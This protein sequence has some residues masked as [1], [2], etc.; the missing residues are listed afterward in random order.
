MSQKLSPVWQHCSNKKLQA[1]AIVLGFHS[2]EKILVFK[3]LKYL[4]APEKEIAK[5]ES[6]TNT[7]WG[8]E[9]MRSNL[10]LKHTPRMQIRHAD[11]LKRNFKDKNKT[12]DDSACFAIND[13]YFAQTDLVNQAEIRMWWILN[14]GVNYMQLRK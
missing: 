2:I 1:A 5:T 3:T 8:I 7:R 11:A 9:M 4:F 6:A 10:E 14:R 13:I 12:V